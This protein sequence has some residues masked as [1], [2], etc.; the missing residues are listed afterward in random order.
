[1]LITKELLRSRI[2]KLT[3][4]VLNDGSGVV[5]G[6]PTE[7]DELETRLEVGTR[8]IEH[9]REIEVGETGSFHIPFTSISSVEDQ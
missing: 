5:V 6:V 9:E 1:M 7:V 3:K 2:G 4:F 8:V